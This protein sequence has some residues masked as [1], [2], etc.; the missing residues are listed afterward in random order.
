MIALLAFLTGPQLIVLLTVG[1]LLTAGLL[2][3]GAFFQ[4]RQQ[5][6]TGISMRQELDKMSDDLSI[7]REGIA[8]AD[9]D[10][11]RVTE[12]WPSLTPPIRAAILALV[13]SASGG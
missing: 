12:A 1:L 3:A 10:L 4:L 13:K 5:R 6:T 11:A 2:I 9:P 8:P 7:P